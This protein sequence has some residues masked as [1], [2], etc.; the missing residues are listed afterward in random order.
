MII[1]LR[2]TR[3]GCRTN[4]PTTDKRE[5]KRSPVGTEQSG[6]NVIPFADRFTGRFKFTSNSKRALVKPERYGPFTFN[7]TIVIR[8]CA[9]QGEMKQDMI[10][11]IHVN[12]DRR[13]LVAGC[14][15]QCQ[16]D[17]NAEFRRKMRKCNSLFLGS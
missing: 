4:D 13:A 14:F 5:G 12:R 17:L 11:R 10:K 9:G 1:L 16:S 2:Q 8:F 7:P 6:V 3:D 15:I